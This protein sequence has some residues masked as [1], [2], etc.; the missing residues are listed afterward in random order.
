MH[1]PMLEWKYHIDMINIF[2]KPD[3]GAM[4]WRFICR[5]E[6]NNMA[7]LLVKAVTLTDLHIKLDN[8]TNGVFV[9]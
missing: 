4:R 3:I 6:R 7:D 9:A 5:G 1:R 8:G 2:V